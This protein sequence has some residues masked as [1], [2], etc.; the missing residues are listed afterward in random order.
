VVVQVIV[1]VVV[2]VVQESA[3]DVA[4]DAMGDTAPRGGC[5]CC[6]NC[7][8]CAA[9]ANKWSVPTAV[10]NIVRGRNHFRFAP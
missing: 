5:V 9:D 7:R 4:G 6:Y 2:Q 3:G 8:G 1:Q 10:A